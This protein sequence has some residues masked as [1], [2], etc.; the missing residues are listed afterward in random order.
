MEE[1]QKLIW[2]QRFAVSP[3]KPQDLIQ[4]LGWALETPVL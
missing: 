3:I 2:D 1:D 4:L